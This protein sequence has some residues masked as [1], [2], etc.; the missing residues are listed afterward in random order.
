MEGIARFQWP[1]DLTRRS[2]AARLLRSWVRIPP[3]AWVFVCCVCCQV[4][5]VIVRAELQIQK[6]GR[7]RLQYIVRLL[8]RYILEVMRK[9]MKNSIGINDLMKTKLEPY[10][11]RRRL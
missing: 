7:I 2:T 3:G 11:F 5:E 1:R 4:E 6:K 9:D 8:S 10:T